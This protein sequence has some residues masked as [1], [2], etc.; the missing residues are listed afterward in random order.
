MLN[1]FTKKLD[2]ILPRIYNIFTNWWRSNKTKKVP[3][4]QEDEEG[5]L[6]AYGK[7]LS[8]KKLKLSGAMISKE[9]SLWNFGDE[10]QQKSWM[11]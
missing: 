4:K 9:N 6:G 3:K 8:G 5:R 7:K 1:N 10:T 2:C 11:D